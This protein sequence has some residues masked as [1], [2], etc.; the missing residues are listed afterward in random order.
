MQAG[1]IKD[2]TFFSNR[3][4]TVSLVSIKNFVAITHEDFVCVFVK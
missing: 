3:V 4:W 2:A 1:L